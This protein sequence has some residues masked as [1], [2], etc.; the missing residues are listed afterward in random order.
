MPQTDAGNREE[1]SL[2]SVLPQWWTEETGSALYPAR[3]ND[4]YVAQSLL[5]IPDVGGI[6]WQEFTWNADTNSRRLGAVKVRVL[7]GASEGLPQ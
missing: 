3:A 5:L 6:H 1:A 7:L 2:V 4:V